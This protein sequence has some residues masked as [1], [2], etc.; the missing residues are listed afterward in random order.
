MVKPMVVHLYSFGQP[1]LSQPLLL[2]RV[3]WKPEGMEWN[4][5]YLLRSNSSD[6]KSKDNNK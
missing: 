5:C 3:K 2:P 6:C 1:A 4:R